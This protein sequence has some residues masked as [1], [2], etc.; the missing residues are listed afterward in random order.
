MRTKSCGNLLSR[1]TSLITG[2]MEQSWFHDSSTCGLALKIFDRTGTSPAPFPAERGSAPKTKIPE[3][4]P[5]KFI[6]T[7]PVANGRL[8]GQSNP[9]QKRSMGSIRVLISM[10]QAFLTDE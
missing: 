2:S 1:I 10:P 8:E 3:L 4:S 9:K 5:F 7:R 6:Q